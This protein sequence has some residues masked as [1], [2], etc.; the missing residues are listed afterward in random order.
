M[1]AVTQTAAGDYP[2]DAAKERRDTVH[3]GV[4]SNFDMVTF[5]NDE[6][7][8]ERD[9]WTIRKVTDFV[10]FPAGLRITGKMKRSLRCKP[11]KVSFKNDPE[12]IIEGYIYGRIEG[13]LFLSHS[14]FLH[15]NYI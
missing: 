13:G 4:L 5:Y 12:R 2:T 3:S 10:T 14:V 9:R 11:F 8:T 6:P 15:Q 7:P 1:P